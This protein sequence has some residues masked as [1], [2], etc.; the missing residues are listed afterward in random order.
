M[1]E[2][3]KTIKFTYKVIDESG[4]VVEQTT[5]KLSDLQKAVS[6]TQEALKNADIGSAK[7]K[8]L[9]DS[10]EQNEKA[11]GKAQVKS[12]G[13]F[14]TLAKSGGPIGTVVSGFQGMGKAAMA[15]VAN[16]IGAVV[17]AL[18]LAFTGI[19]KALTSTEKGMFALN[20]IFGA[21]SGIIS[22]VVKPLGEIAA[23]L[24]E[25]LAA[26]I[27][28]VLSGLEAL[29]LDF[30][31]SANEGAKLAQT[32]NEIDEAEGDLAVARA[33][34]NKELA[35]AKELLT[36]TNASYEDRKV[37]LDKIKVAEEALAAREVALAQK[38]LEAARTRL[39]L[40]GESK[41]NLDAEE[42][43]LIKLA[44][45]EESYAAKQRQFNKEE[46]K[47]AAENAAAV[48]AAQD[49]KIKKAKEYADARKAALDKIRTYEQENALLEEEDE[50]KREI[51]AQE[52]ARQAQLREIEAMKLT[53]TEKAK[54]KEEIEEN[55][56][57]KLAEI[58]DKY[59]KKREDKA[60]EDGE[61]A[62]QLA[63]EVADALALSREEKFAR[64][65]QQIKDNYDELIKQSEGNAEQQKLLQEARDKAL[66][67]G[68]KAYNDE[69]VK[70]TEDTAAK[71]RAID[72]A[73]FEFKMAKINQGIDIAAQAGA[74]LGQLAGEN[75]KLAIAGVVVEQGAAIAKVITST[76]IA[77]AGAL[78]TPQAIAT[79]GA[80]AVPV[81][82]MNNISAGL[83]IAGII[84]AAAKAISD[85]N[86]AETAGG[87][88][89]GGS[90][91]MPSTY[92]NGGLLTGRRHANGGIMTP[93][94]ELEG[95]EFVVNRAATSSFLPILESIN[96]MG[97]GRNGA[98]NNLGA[99]IEG[100]MSGSNPVFKT[101]VVASDVTSQQ[102]A[103]KRIQDL[104]KL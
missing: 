50:Q 39:K 6:S 89:A 42:A 98:Q 85:I 90:K 9:K 5:S 62:K 80:A 84:A 21:F 46:K 69:T 26:S 23:I 38:T 99:N 65:Q 96:S 13:L 88:D 94:G 97:I 1:A 91:V 18:G 104:A 25:K 95:G 34:Q 93:M 73:A 47:L 72:Q 27:E 71:Q 15:F 40:Q 81:I 24:G 7:W 61:K 36:D 75:K 103:D 17:A 67:D 20:R 53:A 30:A 48:K 12:D 82:T 63:N 31:K 4:N 10:V 56:Q 16:P 100:N 33:Q 52:F 59:A 55:N 83:N 41:E 79:S 8:E 51:K 60:K 87:G 77:N 66:L 76:K 44:Q 3:N 78:A 74:L 43:A 58:E 35:V 22:A 49:E 92:A 86:K 54:L 57:L 28:F 14:N 102:E 19:Y 64:E 68:Q 37:A 2:T 70:M 45:T 29:G 101:Y 32:I 11:L